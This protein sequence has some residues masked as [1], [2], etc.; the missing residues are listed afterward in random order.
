[1]K[2]GPLRYWQQEVGWGATDPSLG[3]LRG[4]IVPWRLGETSS[5]RKC[6]AKEQM[7]RYGHSL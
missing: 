3:E 1:M 5:L 6:L 2:K 7:G 4:W